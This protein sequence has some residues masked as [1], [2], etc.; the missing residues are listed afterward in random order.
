MNLEEDPDLLFIAIEGLKA[1]LPEPWK[2]CRTKSGEIYYFN[3]ESG[4]STWE[5]PLDEIYRQK[6]KTLKAT[7][8]KTKQHKDNKNPTYKT[9]SQGQINQAMRSPDASMINK[10]GLSFSNTNENS[11]LSGL[12]NSN[13]NISMNINNDQ[14]LRKNK[15]VAEQN[16]NN[17]EVITKI[18]SIENNQKNKNDENI[19]Y[20]EQSL[21]FSDLNLDPD[22]KFKGEELAKV[23]DEVDNEYRTFANIKENDLKDMLNNQIIEIEEKLKLDS[24]NI[25]SGFNNEL[26]EFKKN[27][28]KNIEID[29]TEEKE[30]IKFKL[31]KNFE[32]LN[33][34]EEVDYDY[35]EKSEQN[36][37]KK[38]LFEMKSTIVLEN[39]KEKKELLDKIADL[40]FKKTEILTDQDKDYKIRYEKEKQIQIESL[41]KKMLEEYNS[42]LIIFEKEEESTLNQELNNY[43][44]DLQ[45]KIEKEKAV[46]Y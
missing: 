10:T 43:I 45:I 6:Y 30:Q 27:L 22:Y 32:S 25:K 44:Q 39:Q 34:I 35:L 3:F 24:N 7:K 1:P 38:F 26:E 17:N 9:N 21:T 13:P 37:T 11:L 20:L 14:Y 29:P 33:K 15:R 28:N 40:C 4:D 23:C 18:K 36:N 8:N 2:A 16:L 12:S 31:A 42:T 46:S 41:K 19:S 5:H